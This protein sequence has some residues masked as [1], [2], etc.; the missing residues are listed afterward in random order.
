MKTDLVLCLSPDAKL[1]ALDRAVM[2]R[3]IAAIG[4]L[5][6]ACLP[7]PSFAQQTSKPCDEQGYD[8][9][10]RADAQS[11]AVLLLDGQP[12]FYFRFDAKLKQL[13]AGPDTKKN[14]AD[15]TV[16]IMALN[17]YDPQDVTLTKQGNDIAYTIDGWRIKV[18]ESIGSLANAHI[19]DLK[20]TIAKIEGDVNRLPTDDRPVFVADFNRD[21]KK[22]HLPFLSRLRADGSIEIIQTQ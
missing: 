16:L 17:C 22:A 5:I 15:E 4:L 3:L 13:R 1:A 21:A 11:L 20:T 10:L 14:T 2:V 19:Q 6:V 9:A 8:P 12:S 18:N 7:S